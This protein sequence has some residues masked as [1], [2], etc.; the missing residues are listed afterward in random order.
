MAGPH[1]EKPVRRDLAG[2]VLLDK[3]TGMTSNRALQIVKRIF[4]ATK[5]GHTGS[6]DPLATGMLPICFG[7]ATKVSGLLLNSA[8]SYHVTALLGTGTDTGDADG[9][10][11]AKESPA[12]RDTE[13]VALALA[14]FLGESDQ[15]PP[16]YSALKQ[17][18]RRLYELAR[19]GQEVERSPRR[20]TISR[21]QLEA[22]DWP[23]VQFVVDCSKGTYVRSLVADFAARLGTAGHVTALRRVWVAPFAEHQMIELERLKRLGQEGSESLDRQLLAADSALSDWPTVALSEPQTTQLFHGQRLLGDASWPVGLVRL[24]GPGIR[25]LGIGEVLPTRELRSKRLFVG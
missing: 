9:T 21:I 23:S 13:E 11:I 3:P 12:A 14:S 22:L 5:A 4:S 10:I 17:N 16:M 25:F 8:K 15:V 6:L 19:L 7:S 20:V 18:G 1:G 2:I 24:Y